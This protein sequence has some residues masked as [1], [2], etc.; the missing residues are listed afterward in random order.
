MSD[1]KEFTTKLKESIDKFAANMEAAQ[2]VI[3]EAAESI[4]K[5]VNGFAEFI[6]KMQLNF[7]REP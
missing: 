1:L 2:I 7:K 4:T 5:D 6:K 3:R